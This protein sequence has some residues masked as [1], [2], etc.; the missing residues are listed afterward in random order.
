MKLT[1]MDIQ[2]SVEGHGQ[3]QH[4]FKLLLNN[5]K[6]NAEQCEIEILNSSVFIN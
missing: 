6:E 1:K 5:V 4:G 3:C 2:T